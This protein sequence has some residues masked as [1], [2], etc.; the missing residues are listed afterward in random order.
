[1]PDLDQDDLPL[2]ESGYTG[3]DIDSLSMIVG[4]EAHR[5]LNEA[6]LQPDP[7]LVAQGW[8]R[9]FMGDG[10]RVKEAVELYEQTGYEVLTV[11]VRPAELADDCEGCRVVVAFQFQ[12]VYTRRKG[13]A[14]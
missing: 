11:P 8:D 7:E 14:K 5:T 1:M 9:R 13:D 6:Q 4:Q 3:K 2:E 12:T 10:R